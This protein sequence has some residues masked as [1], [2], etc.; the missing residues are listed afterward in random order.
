MQVL[1]WAYFLFKRLCK[2][3]SFLFILFLIPLLVVAFG[4]LAEGDSGVLSVALAQQGEG[5][6]LSSSILQ[7]LRAERGLVRFLSCDSP[8]TAEEWVRSGRVN[9]AWIFSDR[10]EDRVVELFSSSDAEPLVTVLERESTVPLRLVSE[11]LS[12]ALFEA[13]SRRAFLNYVRRNSPDAAALSDED[14]L[15][16]YENAFTSANQLF[17]FADTEGGMSRAEGGNYL[18]TPLR[19]L[20][21]VVVVICAFASAMYYVQ[22]R[23]RGL[24]SLLPEGRMPYVELGYHFVSV[25]PVALACFVALRLSGLTGFWLREVVITLLYSLCVAVFACFMRSLCGSVSSLG[26]VLPVVAVGMIALCPVFFDWTEWAL[27]RRLFPPTYSIN[28]AFDPLVLAEM[29]VYTLLLWGGYRLLSVL[30]KV[31]K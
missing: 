28:A 31:K 3:I 14:L 2:K 26:A 1:K 13:C 6:D 11:K 23:E 10:L 20:L 29:S 19:G 30:R 24:F 25:F 18:T 5:D 4:F 8:Q 12:G 22:D 21:S 15:Q 16:Y 17:V 27:L 9:A 7:T